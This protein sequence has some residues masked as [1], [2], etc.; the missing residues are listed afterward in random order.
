MTAPA[1]IVTFG[2]IVARAPIQEP[3]PIVIGRG[4][5]AP[6]PTVVLA[7]LVPPCHQRHLV[8]ELHAIPDL[9]GRGRIEAAA[10]IDENVIAESQPKTLL[11]LKST[12]N[13]ALF[14]YRRAEQSKKTSAQTTAHLIVKQQKRQQVVKALIDEEELPSEFS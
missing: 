3:S 1:P 7:D 9:N 5:C 12:S 13:E 2:R 4:A 10:S 11:N 6:C 14:S 8:R